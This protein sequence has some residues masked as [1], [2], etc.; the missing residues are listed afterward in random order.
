L[1]GGFFKQ[2]EEQLYKNKHF[3]KKVAVADR[4]AYIASLFPQG[5][6][7]IATDYTSFEASFSPE[8]LCAVEMQLYRYMAKNLPN[9]RELI[10][11]IRLALVGRQHC[12]MGSRG[13]G[14]VVYSV[15]GTRM[16][17]DM[18]TS[19][20]NGFTNLILMSWWFYHHGG[21]RDD[22]VGVVEGDDGLFVCKGPVPNGVDFR[23]LGFSLKISREPDASSAGFCGNFFVRGQN[24]A[25]CD[26]LKVILKGGWTMSE[27][28]RGSKKDREALLRAKALSLL[29]TNAGTPVAQPWAEWVLRCIGAKGKIAFSGRYGSSQWWER[30][31]ESRVRAGKCQP[32]NITMQARELIYQKFSL[33]VQWQ[34]SVERWFMEQKQLCP[35]PSYVLGHALLP[36]WR[37]AWVDVVDVEES[38][39]FFVGRDLFK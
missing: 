3:V 38:D 22:V 27:L 23:R 29:A 9:G 12:R 8:I 5:T 31:I 1:T 26:P 16:S 7:V 17:G 32:K 37:E 39:K 25:L 4:P 35:I 20:G 30:D 2:V 28:R 34:V 24:N 33:G 6:E 36:Q 13:S 18:C 11:H 21:R 10:E 19:L 14:G 15:N